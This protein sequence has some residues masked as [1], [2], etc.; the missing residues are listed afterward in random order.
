MGEQRRAE[1]E[2]LRFFYL[3]PVWAR[4]SRGYEWKEQISADI[5]NVLGTLLMY[6]LPAEKSSP[7]PSSK[8][9]G[10]GD[11][12][13][14]LFINSS[15]CLSNTNLKFWRLPLKKEKQMIVSLSFLQVECVINSLKNQSSKEENLT[16]GRFSKVPVVAEMLV[17]LYFFFFI[18]KPKARTRTF[19]YGFQGASSV[20]Y[21]YTIISLVLRAKFVPSLS[22]TAP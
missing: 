22:C 15:T 6:K 16:R 20:Y 2:S 7:S 19:H 10:L 8:S 21:D 4:E 9:D 17:C 12:Q 18:H 3:S 14:V 13:L 11:R 1:S 5:R